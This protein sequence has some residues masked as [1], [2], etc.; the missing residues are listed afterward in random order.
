MEA[1]DGLPLYVP[2][3]R[4]AEIA[5]VGYATMRSWCLDRRDPLPH[6]RVGKAK[7]MVRTDCLAD[8]LRAREEGARAPMKR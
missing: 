1:T 7:L 5:G 2:V 8:A 3:K 6:I 4:A